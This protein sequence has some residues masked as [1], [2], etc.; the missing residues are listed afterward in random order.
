MPTLLEQLQAK[1]PGKYRPL[2]WRDLGS[3]FTGGADYQQWQ[4][5]PAQG[6]VAPISP[7]MAGAPLTAPGAPGKA[8]AGAA[9][10]LFP[11]QVPGSE[12]FPPV[13]DGNPINNFLRSL[14]SSTLN[15]PQ[16]VYAAANY[17]NPLVGKPAAPAP[18]PADP[19]ALGGVPAVPRTGFRASGPG[20]P[21]SYSIPLGGAKPPAGRTPGFQRYL[22]NFEGTGDNPRSTASGPGQFVDGTFEMFLKDRYPDLHEQVTS[23]SGRDRKALNRSLKKDLGE[24]A[25]DWYREYNR[26]QLAAADLPVDDVTLSLSHFLGPDG[27]KKLLRANPNT[28]VSE[29]LSADAIRSN[30]EVLSGRNVGQV[31]DHMRRVTDTSATPRPPELP[32][33]P[34]QAVPGQLDYSATRGWLDKAAPKPLDQRALETMLTNDVL[35]RAAAGAGGV[36]ATRP[37]SFASALAGAG[38]GAAQGATEGTK[39]NFKQQLEH[40]AAQRNYATTRAGNEQHITET[41]GR[42][43]QLIDEV[44]FQ[45]AKRTYENTVQNMENEYK[46]KVGE[47]SALMPQIKSDTNGLTIQ[48]YD[49]STNSMK[50]TVH[51][52]SI[53]DK[54]E[55]LKN[56]ATAM[57]LLDPSGIPAQSIE[58]DSIMKSAGGS[59]E[60]AMALVRQQAIR[61]AVRSGNG[62][63]FGP[64]FDKFQKDAIQQLNRSAPGMKPEDQLREV[65]NIVAS[66]IFN[67]LQANPAQWQQALNLLARSGNLAAQ[68]SIGAQGGR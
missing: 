46:W 13:P 36:D 9:Q 15:M 40:E 11:A 26:G 63:L 24:E 34:S 10:G 45:N 57:N 66:S 8:W 32:R 58:L 42:Q 51:P 68:L 21:Q 55:D 35:S 19:A 31:I 2:T 4:A 22:T 67:K 54:A 53:F 59:P 30:P 49:P 20:A 61:H 47:R 17:I 27:A 44:S 6:P 1:E 56:M 14:A 52:K 16:N 29:L 41:Q 3:I 65:N 39:F 48:Q 43:Q 62:R 5:D 12:M 25:T 23:S 37:G 64:D 50:L 60:A 28:P 7:L 18:A 33:P 38:A